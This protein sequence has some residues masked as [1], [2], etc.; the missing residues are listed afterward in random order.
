MTIRP[1]DDTADASLAAAV[2]PR[3]AVPP[4]GYVTVA[5]GD[6]GASRADRPVRMSRIYAQLVA[7]AA[8]VLVAVAVVG[9]YAS[10]TVAEREAMNDAAQ[11]TDLLGEA[12]VQPAIRDGL[13]T[14]DKAAYAALDDA[15]RTHVVGGVVTRV[16]VWTPDGTVVYSD[17]P[18]VV[19]SRFELGDEEREVLA[20]ATTH[21]EI[22]DLTK[23]ENRFEHNDTKLLE[24]Y[25]PVWTPSGSPLLFET[26]LPYD[27]VSARTGALWR[28][29]AGITVSSLLLLLV[30]M[31]PVIWRLLDRVRAAQAQRVA[32]LEHAVDASSDERRRIA[33]TL[34]DGVVQELAAASFAV[35]GAAERAEADGRSDLADVVRRAGASVRGSIGSLRTLLVDIYPPNLQSAGLG[36]ALTDLAETARTPDRQ[37]TL[38]LPREV[39]IRLDEERE[40]LIYRVAQE[41][42][43]NAVRHSAAQHIDVSLTVVGRDVELV[44]ADDGRGFDTS[45]ALDRHQAGHFGVQ[46]MRDLSTR[47]GATLD[48]ASAPGQG[49]RWRLT[50]PQT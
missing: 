30:L 45:V 17:E 22:S 50:V 32:L 15:V 33:A 46:V 14:G 19:G 10:R 49:T 48:V 29:F 36:A 38:T 1:T 13:I 4:P 43:R 21:A 9:G 47:Y 12:V 40:R 28:G 20:T 8:V 37:V 35:G 24:V 44:V 2:P 16:K 23:P 34:H 5:R 7:A 27:T 25:R 31:L 41:S 26:Y 18:R 39:H 3:V 11:T 42:L 6:A